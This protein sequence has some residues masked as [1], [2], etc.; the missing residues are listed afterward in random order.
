MRYALV[1]LLSACPCLAGTVPTSPLSF[2]PNLGQTDPAIKFLAHSGARAIY[3]TNSGL[4][5]SG[6]ELQFSGGNC[7]VISGR[8]PLSERHNYFRGSPSR[9]KAFTNIPTYQ[10]VRCERIYPGIDAEFYGDH[11]AL[12]YDLILAPQADT[13]VIRLAWKQVKSVQ[14][15]RDGDLMVE[16]PEGILRQHKPVVYQESKQ[17]RKLIDARY[18]LAGAN[19]VRVSFGAYDRDL[20]LIVDPVLF[21]VDANAAP[22]GP[23]A[24]DSSGNIYLA[25]TTETSSFDSTAGAVQPVFGGGTCESGSIEPS[26]PP[27]FY[28]CPDAVRDQGGPERRG[29]LRD[30]SRRQWRRRRNCHRGRLERQR[31][32][33]RHNQPGELIHSQQ[34]PCYFRRGLHQAEC[35]W[36]G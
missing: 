28:P 21:A 33:C 19:E 18:V 11:G 23:I 34:F 35:G 15:D 27:T 10:R 14:I 26:T 9:R 8:Q 36:R 7:P 13:S 5:I 31:L 29:D 24:V 4:R 2:E 32:Y 3:L 30:V 12:E 16:A 20:P 22:A 6:A 17:G 1:V 25:G